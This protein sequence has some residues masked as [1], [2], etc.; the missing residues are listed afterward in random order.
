MASGWSTSCRR[1]SAH[2][3]LSRYFTSPTVALAAANTPSS[4]DCNM[5]SSKG[6]ASQV[7]RRKRR[8]NTSAMARQ[9]NF[10]SR[11]CRRSASWWPKSRSASM[12]LARHSVTL[13]ATSATGSAARRRRMSLRPSGSMR[14][15]RSS[16]SRTHSS[17]RRRRSKSPPSRRSRTQ[18][19]PS[20]PR[21]WA[22]TVL[23]MRGTTA[24]GFQSM[25]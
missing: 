16:R 14:G 10:S 8:V 3:S 20:T 18:R 6:R 4:S 23:D 19:A 22:T 5:S 25:C 21:S 7:K 24:C 13:L 2:C 9:T 11:S 17:R 12:A 15:W 1:R